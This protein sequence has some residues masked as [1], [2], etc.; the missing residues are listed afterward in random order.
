MRQSLVG[1]LAARSIA[2]RGE[3]KMVNLL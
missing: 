2:E 3:D 1:S